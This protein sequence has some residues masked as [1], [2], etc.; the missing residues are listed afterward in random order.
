MS[1]KSKGHGAGSETREDVNECMDALNK[2]SPHKF[3]IRHLRTL[4]EASLIK[5]IIRPIISKL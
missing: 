1:S 5:A 4:N 3:T 2:K